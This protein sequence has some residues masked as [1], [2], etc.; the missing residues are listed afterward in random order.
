MKKLTILLFSILIS[1]NSYGEDDMYDFG[2][3]LA[4]CSGDFELSSQVILLGDYGESQSQAVKERANGWLVASVVFFM[5]DGMGSEGAWSAAQG[6]KD[7]TIST[8]MA[9]IEFATNSA[10][11]DKEKDENLSK[12]FNDLGDLI[13]ECISYENL[14][15]ESIKTYR[16]MVY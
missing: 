16:K 10:W 12:V 5:A 13:P 15:E 1:F 11:S 3:K 7:T 9:K 2:H 14:V 8:W 4:T 6:V